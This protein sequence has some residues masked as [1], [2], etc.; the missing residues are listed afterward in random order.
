V[1]TTAVEPRVFAVTY[2][3][4][5]WTANKATGMHWADKGRL[6]AEWRDAFAKLARHAKVPHL[7]R[8]AVTV[9]T[10]LKGRRAQDI[11]ANFPAVKA[12]IDGL[13]DAGVIVDDDAEHLVSLTFLPPI[14]GAAVDEL[15]L[16]VAE[17]MA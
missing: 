16:V 2:Q 17:V 15:T 14:F 6:V 7:D 5:G 9:E 10:H 13:V 4:R 8:I 11:A 3:A 1:S 12:G